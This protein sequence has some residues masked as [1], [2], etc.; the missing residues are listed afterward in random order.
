MMDAVHQNQ[1]Y[2]SWSSPDAHIESCI[3]H[4]NERDN[5]AY[6]SSGSHSYVCLFHPDTVFAT[7]PTLVCRRRWCKRACR[8]WP[9][10][11]PM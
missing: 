3:H 1:Y 8:C 9:P 2:L 5:C 11:A 10:R 6:I 7:L 4:S